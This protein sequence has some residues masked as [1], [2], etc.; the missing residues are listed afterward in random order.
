MA[1]QVFD[2]IGGDS[3]SDESAALDRGKVLAFLEGDGQKYDLYE[4]DNII[5]RSINKDLDVK[6]LDTSVSDVHANL[7]LSEAGECYCKDLASNNG[8]INEH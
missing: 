7:E 4:G 3:G 1:T 6:L 8:K 2:D 5:G